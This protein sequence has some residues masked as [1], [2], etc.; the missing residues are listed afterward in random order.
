MEV[1]NRRFLFVGRDCGLTLPQK[2]FLKE[3][4]YG[5]N[6]SNITAISGR[7]GVAQ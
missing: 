2:L 5:K 1:L 7:A 3:F 6:E 4:V